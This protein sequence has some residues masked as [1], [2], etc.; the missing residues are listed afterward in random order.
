MKELKGYE[1]AKVLTGESSQLP[2]GGYIVKILS[3]KALNRS[4]YDCLEFSFDIVEGEHRNHYTDLYKASTD[5]NK[6]WK[7]VYSTLIPQEDSQYYEDNLTKFK[8]LMTN[9]EESNNGYHWDWDESKLKDKLIG[10]V[11]GEE[12]FKPQDKDETIMLSRPRFFTSIQAI[13]DG[14]FKIPKPK[15]LKKDSNTDFLSEMKN[16]SDE[17][18]PF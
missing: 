11:Y 2:V 3:C 6:R 7:G 8:T 5:D 1:K 15:M 18:L 16:A 12:E 4:G 17:G 14:K 9:F 10:V 13:K